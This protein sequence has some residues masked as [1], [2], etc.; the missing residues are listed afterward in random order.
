MVHYK[1][2]HK[3]KQPISN[4]SSKKKH[5]HGFGS[6]IKSFFTIPEEDLKEE[7]CKKKFGTTKL[8]TITKANL[9]IGILIFMF[10]INI[11]VGLDVKFLY[12]RQIL[13]FLFLITIPG[14]L[15][16]LCFKIKNTGFWE[17]LVY[18]IG[19]SIAFIMFAGLTVNWT[20]P[21][22]G[23]TDKPLSLWPILISFNIFLLALWVTALN[24]NDDFKPKP[25]LIPKLD[26]LN[27]I[28]FIIPMFFPILSVLGAFLLN[29]HGPNILTMIM[30]GGIAVYVLLLVLFRKRLNHNIY[31]WALWMI[32]LALLFSGWMRGWFIN[33]ADNSLE[34]YI[35]KL[36]LSKSQ[37]SLSNYYHTYNAMLSLNIL[38]SIIGMILNIKDQFLF[39]F[40]FQIITSFMMIISYIYIKKIFNLRIAFL[41]TLFF[42]SLPMLYSGTSIAIRQEMALLFFGLMILSLFTKEI[43][44]S[45]KKTL[46]VIFGASMIVSHYSTAYIALAIFSLTYILIFIYKIHE[47]KKIKKGKIYPSQKSEFYLT[48]ALVLLLLLF[49]FLW[50]N[51]VTPTGNGLIDF[52]GRSISNFGNIFNE[53]NQLGNQGVIGNFFTLHNKQNPSQILD[54]YTQLSMNN[55]DIKSTYLSSKYFSPHLTNSYEKNLIYNKNFTLIRIY[56]EFIAR[57]LLVFGFLILLIDWLNK[58]TKNRDTFNEFKLLM[59]SFM[60]VAICLILLPFFSISYDLARFYQQGILVLSPLVILGGLFTFKLF[61]KNKS[62]IIVTCFIFLYFLFISG[63]NFHYLMNPDSTM[64]L[65]NYG[66]EYRRYYT[67]SSI[68]NPFKWLTKNSNGATLNI[69]NVYSYK[70]NIIEVNN[71][72]VKKTVFPY[73]IDKQNYVYSGYNNNFFGFGTSVYN[74]Y[75]FSFN[76]P[77]EFLNDNKNKIY[78]NG[79]SEIFK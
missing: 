41:G 30:L 47:N 31:P 20:L 37:W 4:Y 60:L 6:K 74:S 43:K 24:R 46:F 75:W 51:Q 13:G 49:G 19:L 2:S 1:H 33:G 11:L 14:L 44:Q 16:M 63:F 25:F 26:A 73:N 71:I 3:N 39:K 67:D 68:L 22:L 21:A 28:F 64:R 45:L 54:T 79:G 35:F 12:L 40:Y 5:N 65:G 62:L 53:D 76:F 69:D 61:N 59:I 48:G 42:L 23:I 7:E 8:F 66:G 77:T 18:T 55:S 50:Y 27:N 56:I 15:I 78:N 52:M 29:N 10:I 34:Y 9:F 36:T 32:G 58:W 17:Y 70:L 57:V 72:F 38:P